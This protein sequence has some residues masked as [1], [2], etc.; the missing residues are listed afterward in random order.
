M[1]LHNDRIL[2]YSQQTVRF[3]EHY[4][5][6][7][8]KKEALAIII[9][10]ACGACNFEINTDGTVEHCSTGTVFSQFSAQL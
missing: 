5:P 3:S 9:D 6:T 8:P 4:Y 10:L 7:P 1:D 2:I